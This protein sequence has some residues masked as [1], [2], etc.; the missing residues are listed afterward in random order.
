MSLDKFITRGLVGSVGS[1]DGTWVTKTPQYHG[2]TQQQSAVQHEGG[3]SFVMGGGPLKA[4]PQVAQSG[5]RA[6]YREE[7][8]FFDAEKVRS[9]GTRRTRE[10]G[11]QEDEEGL[12]LF[13]ATNTKKGNQ[14][15]M[16]IALYGIA[17]IV[18]IGLLI[19]YFGSGKNDDF[20]S[21]PAGF[22]RPMRP[23]WDR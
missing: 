17:L 3:T 6:S 1:G 15:V 14:V 23:M 9:S 8:Y 16:A 4:R 5:S 12:S 10:K 22:S 11:S 20:Y 18:G 19:T 2:P 7:R 13:E 21:A